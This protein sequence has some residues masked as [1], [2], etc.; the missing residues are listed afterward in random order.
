MSG[1]ALCLLFANAVHIV[2]DESEGLTLV[3]KLLGNKRGIST[4]YNCAVRIRINS[5]VISDEGARG[6]L[7]L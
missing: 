2:A 7:F 4:G 6:H 3:A 1:E 5:I